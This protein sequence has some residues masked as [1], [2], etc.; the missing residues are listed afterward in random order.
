LGQVLL[1]FL[2]VLGQVPQAHQVYSFLIKFIK[3][4]FNLASGSQPSQPLEPPQPLEPSQPL[5]PTKTLQPIRVA[6]PASTSGKKRKLLCITDIE[7]PLKHLKPKEQASQKII[8]DWSD[9]HGGAKYFFD[10]ERKIRHEY[11]REIKLF[12]VDSREMEPLNVIGYDVGDFVLDE[13]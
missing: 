12:D 5:Q 2:Q 3:F 7:Y 11:I 8:K 10:G 13:E 4:I 1:V 9:E 6:K